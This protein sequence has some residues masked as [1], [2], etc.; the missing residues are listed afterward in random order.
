MYFI[1]YVHF[2]GSKDVIT[3][4]KMHRMESLKTFPYVV[5]CV[6]TPWKLFL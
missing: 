6:T 5:V 2:V 1:A 3:V 4:R